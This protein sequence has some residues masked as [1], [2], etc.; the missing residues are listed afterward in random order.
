[1]DKFNLD[2]FLRYLITG[3]FFVFLNY[4]MINLDVVN[5]EISTL[6]KESVPTIAVGL[7]LLS[8]FVIYVIYRAFFYPLILNYVATYL[9]NGLRR[10]AMPEFVGKGLD[11]T[12]TLTDLKRWGIGDSKRKGLTEWAGQ[13][14]FLYNMAISCLLVSFLQ[15]ANQTIYKEG[16]NLILAGIILLSLAM[17]HH[18]R[19]KRFEIRAIKEI[20]S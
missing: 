20:P 4:I 12:I 11:E 18:L 19:Y 2:E 17:I 7:C 6:G 1:M 16:I 9:T 14:H 10:K 8:G 15:K 13:I 3:I 5:K